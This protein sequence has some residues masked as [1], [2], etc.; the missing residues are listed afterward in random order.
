MALY[1]RKYHVYPGAQMT[2]M[3][4]GARLLAL[5]GDGMR[6]PWLSALVDDERPLVARSLYGV[7]AVTALYP[8]RLP[9]DLDPTAIF[10]GVFVEHLGSEFYLFD[11][12]EAP[13]P[14]A[15]PPPNPAVAPT[16]ARAEGQPMIKCRICHSMSALVRENELDTAENTGRAHVDCAYGHSQYRHVT[17]D[18]VL[19]SRESHKTTQERS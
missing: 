18:E 17:D 7:T 10:V 4:E 16:Q 15:A 2:I 3:P 14:T 19:R 8:T 6:M 12:G 1:I 9:E 5:E 13:A 11:L